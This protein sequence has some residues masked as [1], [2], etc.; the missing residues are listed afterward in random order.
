MPYETDRLRHIDQT[1]RSLSP[2]V[3]AAGETQDCNQAV[4]RDLARALD[5]RDGGAGG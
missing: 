1:I 4:V 5:G 2:L 3:P